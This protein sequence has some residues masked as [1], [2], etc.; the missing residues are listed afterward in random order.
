M[1][2]HELRQKLLTAVAELY[3]LQSVLEHAVRV[4]VP[5]D[6]SHVVQLDTVAK[7]LC[8]VLVKLNVSEPDVS[9][10]YT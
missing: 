6:A 8:G 5:P 9:Q 7:L 4:G 10:E 3:R 1:T 2:K